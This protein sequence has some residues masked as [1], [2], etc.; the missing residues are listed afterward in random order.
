LNAISQIHSFEP[1]LAPRANKWEEI[2]YCVAKEFEF[3]RGNGFNLLKNI[4]S[5]WVILIS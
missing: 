4:K 1:F 5:N 2:D 3:G